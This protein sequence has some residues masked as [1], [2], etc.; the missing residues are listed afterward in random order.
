MNKLKLTHIDTS[1]YLIETDISLFGDNVKNQLEVVKK[2]RDDLNKNRF[3]VRKAKNLAHLN[4]SKSKELKGDAKITF[5]LLF[6]KLKNKYSDDIREI[7]IGNLT[8]SKT[9][10]NIATINEFCTGFLQLQEER[11]K[12]ELPELITEMKNLKE[13]TDEYL[14]KKKDLNFDKKSKIITL[15]DS[16][17]ILQTNFA[18]LKAMIHTESLENKDINFRLYFPSLKRKKTKSQRILLKI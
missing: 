6:A 8:I 18:L 13:T 15:N 1:V 14:S 10:K 17:N 12:N 5:G 9:T 3:I 16:N 7:Y 4:K 11:N 2:S